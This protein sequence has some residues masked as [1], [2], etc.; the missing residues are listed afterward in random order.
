MSPISM[1][2]P[3]WGNVVCCAE[4]SGAGHRLLNPGHTRAIDVCWGC[5]FDLLACVQCG[6]YIECCACGQAHAMEC[7]WPL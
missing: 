4:C 7:P 6:A 1:I 2:H 5:G 3:V